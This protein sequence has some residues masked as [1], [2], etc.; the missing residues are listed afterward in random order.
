MGKKV[1][2]QNCFETNSS[3]MHSIIVTKNDVH[4]TREELLEND[5]RSEN[6][7]PEYVYINEKKGE[8]YIWDL[9]R[10]FGRSP[11]QVL[12]TFQD[13]FKYAMCEYLGYLYPDDPEWEQ[14]ME[15]FQEIAG[16][17]VGAYVTGHNED[18]DIYLDV[19]GNEILHKNLRYDHWDEEKHEAVYYYLDENGDKQIAKLD[20][21]NCIVATKIG[22]IDHQSMGMLRNFL[23]KNKI[24]LKEFLTNKK[25]I[26]IVDGDE[27]CELDNLY[28][29]GLINKDFI[30]SDFDESGGDIEYQEWLKEQE[31]WEKQNE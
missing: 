28:Y 6:Y 30:V 14:N 26:V 4:V 2:R 24:D 8:W 21:E 5:Y 9:D 27:I 12:A 3:S 18:N 22:S 17:V 20:E 19:N 13:K 10:G 23:E 31:E 15:M 11:F 25:Y 1:I 7:S 29:S 16:E